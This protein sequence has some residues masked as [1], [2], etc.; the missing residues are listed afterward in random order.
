MSI[1]NSVALE[2]RRALSAQNHRRIGE[3][4]SPAQNALLDILQR[5][6]RRGNARA[7]RALGRR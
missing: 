1:A 4:L 6:G 5:R 3:T 2:D 7:S